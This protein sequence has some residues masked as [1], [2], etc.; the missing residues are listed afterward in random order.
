[1]GRTVLKKACLDNQNVLSAG[2][3]QD[4]V[5]LNYEMPTYRGMDQKRSRFPPN[6]PM[7]IGIIK[8]DNQWAIPYLTVINIPIS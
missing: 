6:G 8:K 7:W 1:V 3:K 5:L 4:F 2:Y